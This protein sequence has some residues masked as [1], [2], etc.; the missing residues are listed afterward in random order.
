MRL[1]AKR[2]RMHHYFA[3]NLAD[4]PVKSESIDTAVHLFAPFN[5]SEF[6]RVLKPHGTLYSVIPGQNHLFEMKKVIFMIC[7][8]KMM[9]RLRTAVC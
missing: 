1:A 9:K 2:N 5:D 7:L 6:A 3:A 8:I 4:I